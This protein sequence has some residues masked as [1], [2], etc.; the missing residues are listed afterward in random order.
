MRIDIQKAEWNSEKV[1]V[2]IYARKRKVEEEQ[3]GWSILTFLLGIEGTGNLVKSDPVSFRVPTEYIEREYTFKMKIG[4]GTTPIVTLT[5]GDVK[6][7]E[8]I[9]QK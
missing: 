8:L 5:C 9:L 6:F 7:K 3:D 2:T 1:I 4:T